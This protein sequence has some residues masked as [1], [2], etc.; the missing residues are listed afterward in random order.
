MYTMWTSLEPSQPEE[1]VV[2][3]MLCCPDCQKKE[4]VVKNTF[5]RLASL[6][7]CLKC[8]RSEKSQVQSGW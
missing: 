1:L 3:Y 7:L 4:P 2:G 5:C 6:D 8:L